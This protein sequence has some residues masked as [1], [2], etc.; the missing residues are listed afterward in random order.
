M[1]IT[2]WKGV[3]VADTLD[4]KGALRNAGFLLHE[5]TTCNLK[6]EKCKACRAE[7]GRRF[8]S[9]RMESATRLKQFC[10]Q[11]ALGVMR[12]HLTRLEKSRAVDAP[13][14]IPRSEKVRSLGWDYKGYQKAG[15]AYAIQRKD[16]LIGDDMGLGKTIQA[17]GFVNYTKPKNVIVTCPKTVMFNWRDEALTWLVDDYEIV[18]V[19]SK[20]TEIPQR[21]GLFVI[22]NYQKLIGKTPLS[23]SLARIWDVLISDECQ[24]L[25]NID[26]ETSKSILGDTGLMRRSHRTLFLTGTPIE[27]YPKEIWAIA[28]SVCP[29]KFGDWWEFMA[30]Y[31]G[32]HQEERKYEKVDKETG[33]KETYAKKIW[34]DTGGTRL[35]EL[36]QRLRATFMVR[37]LKSDV[38]KEL[39]PKR[40]QL[41]LLEDTKVD[42]SKDPDFK[43]WRELY[44]AEYEEKLA[45]LEAAKTSDDY[46]SAALALEN[47]TG[48]AFEEMSEFRHKTALAKL[49]LCL[50]YTE[51]MMGSG[52]GNVVIW[53]HHR[54]VM[55]QTFETFKNDAVMV[56]GNTPDRGPRSRENMVKMFQAG[57]KKI[58]IGQIRAAG[59]GITLT[60]CNTTIFYEIDWV[61][62]VLSQCEDRLCRIGQ[63]KMVHVIHLLLGGTLDANMARKI[64]Q[65]Q[66]VIDRALDKMPELKLRKMAI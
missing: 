14:E 7:I 37:R 26:T 64:V 50:Q 33:K 42:W 57:Q 18:L 66:E 35:A 13:I 45:K 6:Q 61:P 51:Q 54:D 17:L 3:F 19:N 36:Q 16:T 49:P 1:I 4:E 12:D 56:H 30:R 47:F 59:A 38:L 58:F 21:D 53:C 63:K 65:K 20:L 43:R 40:R 39:P 29:A 62:G 34:V 52:L 24:A 55:E 28:A 44:E 46:K 31:A 11:R 22:V 8:W 2:Y 48:I 32:L 41:I 27:N 15:V 9:D 25:K 5:P 23:K 60:A 10:N